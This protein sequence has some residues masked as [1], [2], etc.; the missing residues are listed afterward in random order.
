MTKF[1]W[2]GALK[3]ATGIFA[4]A[5]LFPG[6]GGAA[7]NISDTPLFLG[8]NQP[9]LTLL[10]MGRDHKLYYEA[11]NDASDLDGDGDLEV[12][13]KPALDYYG[14]FD[15]YTCY[16][17][18]TVNGRFNPSGSSASKKCS[19]KW[20]G[21]FLNY[22]TMSRMDLLRKVLYGG[23]R[24]VDST[25]ETVL[26]RSHIPQDAHSWG[27]EYT[28][29]AIDGYD[30]SE[31]APYSL[32]NAGKRH[33]FANTTLLNDASKGPLLRVSLNQSKRIWDWVSKERPVADSSVSPISDLAVRV[34]VCN[35]TAPESNCKRYPNGNYKPT[36]LL[37][38]HG[39]NDG[40]AFGLLTGSYAKHMSGG[41]LRKPV[42]SFVDEVNANDGRFTAINGIVKTIDKLKTVG[43]GGNYV[44]N[45][46][47]NAATRPMNEGE[48][49]MW[50]NPIAEMMYE[51]LRYFAGKKQ[52]TAAFSIAS[53]G[54]DD[55][56]L[57][58]PL[59]TW[60]DPYDT[61][62]AKECAKAFQLVISDINPSYDTDQL[63][64]SEF[65]SF[66]GDLAGLN[67]S[68]LAQTITA[69][70]PDV[71][72]LRFIG[73]SNGVY[74]G[75]PTAKAV[76]GLHNI[77][78]LAPEEPT[79][80]GGYY[81]SSVAYFGKLTDLHTAN[82]KQQVETLA[83][84]LASPLPR[85]EIPVG[86]QTVTLVPFGKSPGGAVGTNVIT[87]TKGD[88]QP[89][90]QIVD[91]YVIQVNNT[92][93][94]NTDAGV[95][96]G[97]PFYR[98][99][100][101]FED[102]EQGGDHDMDAIVEYT[103]AVTANGQI[104]V[105]LE[106]TYAA[107]SIIQHMGYVISGTTADGTYLEVRDKDTDAT[108]DPDY[109]LDTPPGVLP[110]TEEGWK[111]NV[112]LPLSATRTF[113]P[114]STPA[115]TLLKDPLWYAA[116][117]GGFKDLN[118]NN[119]PDPGEWDARKAGQPD[120]YFPV[121]NP[122]HLQQQLAAAFDLLASK[123]DTGTATAVNGLS[124]RTASMV[125][126][127]TFDSSD[128]S[129][130]L[131]AL[132]LNTNGTLGD[133]LWRAGDK[134][135]ATTP[136]QRVVLTW[137]DHLKKGVPFTW[138][139]LSDAQRLALKGS[140]PAETGQDRLD[141]LRGERGQEGT[142]FRQR[143]SLLGD[144][145][146][147]A[148]VYV[149]PPS[150]FQVVAE[151]NKASFREF[152]SANAQRTPMVFVGANDGMVHGFNA[153]T[154]AELL[155]Y[156]PSPGFAK[157]AQLTQPTYGHAAFADGALTVTENLLG[158][159]G[160]VTS[161]VGGLGLGGRAL[162]ALDITDPT[163]FSEANAEDL[164]LW[165]FTHPDLG[166]TFGRPVVTR[167]R[168]GADV[169]LFGSGYNTPNGSAPALY[170]VGLGD[171]NLVR[172]IPIPNTF[173]DNALA[174]VRAVDLDN[175]SE[176]DVVLAGDLHG[177]LWMFDLSANQASEWRIA[178]GT[179]SEPAPAFVA[180]NSA[181]QRQPITTAPVV[182]KHPKGRGL[183]VFFGTGK[184]LEPTDVQSGQVQTFYSIW[185]ADDLENGTLQLNS[186]QFTRD[187]LLQQQILATAENQFLRKDVRVTTNHP[188]D[189]A[190]HKGWYLDL[191]VELGERV[192]QAPF[193]R[194]ERVIFASVT[195]SSDACT[196]GGTSW[197]YE[198]DLT[199]GSR[200]KTPP[201]DFNNDNSFDLKDYVTVDWDVNGDGKINA[202]D[203][204][205]GSALRL[206]DA[207]VVFLDGNA[208]LTHG[209]SEIKML[210]TSLG[211]VQPV[212]ESG[213]SSPPTTWRQL[214][215]P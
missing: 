77:R 35:S 59:P 106:S 153:T 53:S 150:A 111:D 187:D 161:L 182:R 42:G 100:I 75:A 63:P 162:F 34:S 197:I 202:S 94:G 7:L 121:T 49:R 138:G 136:S 74:D 210:G 163:A 24:A 119:R 149:P 120:N 127:A 107:G 3:R 6:V 198:V 105:A 156:V 144:V 195:P 204:V 71:A 72:G 89:T 207:G 29:V 137:N 193:L 44:Y 79:K 33:L 152:V 169:V 213:S 114:S 73:E 52:P 116:K 48:C 37:H 123:A 184:Y 171:G 199:S 16:T 2:I 56:T 30:I 95:N 66:S 62:G 143:G 206:D 194:G 78:G 205:V 11:Y 88:Y 189:W 177:N 54:N 76:Q 125:F 32:P 122:I 10:V 80:Q 130:D 81:A 19:S 191:D 132:A 141:F 160:W 41:V 23:Y 118:G 214:M 83:V 126:Q 178:H 69:Y 135:A 129:G 208:V 164:V 91:F 112:A 145:L 86:G 43:F 4:L 13:F 87:A 55:A 90:N 64:G 103:I 166:Y 18:D 93:A 108:K 157:L 47:W 170:I 148:P 46:G 168:G 155:A 185:I 131:K 58:L 102:V 51:G 60:N 151:A 186:T 201:F 134:L 21:N 139:Q 211:G 128:W 104:E 97:R 9:P 50:G 61:G 96:G 17:Y 1:D 117:W 22:L 154:G 101:N 8:G 36:G 113:T 92:N 203:R 5:L 165:E 109:F 196:G 12:G 192:H 82:G 176:T 167:V 183:Q 85:I 67:V 180:R 57:G 28:S 172:R 159:R 173:T 110:G 212:A 98:F 190:T 38:T 70:E 45:C 209:N 188:I 40:M 39:E 25:T 147:S 175:D 14:Y 26:E 158:D 27:K 174:H 142:T 15:S 68:A 31:Y 146:N 84:A 65:S 179:S 115:A 181:D 20:S 133:V 140:D 200:L 124:T 215:E 99:A